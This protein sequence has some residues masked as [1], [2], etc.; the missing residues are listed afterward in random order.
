MD[1]VLWSTSLH[2]SD[3][4]KTSSADTFKGKEQEFWLVETF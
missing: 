4:D 3:G 2:I 1:F